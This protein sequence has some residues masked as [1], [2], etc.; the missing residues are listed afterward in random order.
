MRRTITILA[1]L[2]LVFAGSCQRI[3]EGLVQ[4]GPDVIEGEVLTVEASFGDFPDTKTAIQSD[5]KSIFWTPGDAINLFFG[6]ISSAKFTTS[7]SMTE[8]SATASFTGTLGAATGSSG[9]GFVAP[10]FWGV[11][12]YDADNTCDGTSVA[13]WIKSEQ[14]AGPGT[15]GNGMSPSV[16]NAPGLGLSFKNVGSWFK[17][18][19]SQEGIT[20]ATF[21]GNNGEILAGRVTVTMDSDGNPL[22]TRILAGS[23]RITVTPEGGGS[24]VPNQ[25]YYITLIP[26]TISGAT[27]Y[28]LTLYK[29]AQVGKLVVADP[30]KTYTFARSNSRSKTNADAGITWEDRY[31]EMAAGFNWAKVNIG[32]ASPEEYG[33]YFAWGETSPRDFYISDNY[34]YLIPFNDAATANRGD[35]WRTPT[36]AEWEALLD[37]NNYTWE[38]TTENGVNGYRVTSKVAGYAGNSI[39]LPTAGYSTN[40][41]VWNTGTTGH[42][43]SSSLNATDARIANKVYIASRDH[44]II[45]RE[46]F[47]GYS[48]RAVY[49][50]SYVPPVSPEV[51]V[52][53][54]SFDMNQYVVTDRDP[55]TLTATISPANATIQDLTWVSSDPSVALISPTGVV[56]GLKVGTTTITVRTVDG[57]YETSCNVTVIPNVSYLDMGNGTKWAGWNVGASSP[58][59]WGNFYAWA[60]TQ[61]KTSYTWSTYNYGSSSSNVTIYTATD[62][63]TVL[64]AGDDAATANL[65]VNWR[66]PTEGEWTWLLENCTWTYAEMNGNKGYIVKSNVS[67]YSNSIIFLPGAGIHLN[68]H[69]N[70]DR[71]FYWSSN[72]S[73]DTYS[74]AKYAVIYEG[75]GRSIKEQYRCYGASVRPIYEP[76]QFLNGHEYVEMGD[77]L[78]WATCNIGAASPEAYG[79]YF[80]WGETAPK[81]S[82]SDES[83]D[84][85]RTFSDAAAANWGGTWRMPTE[86]EWE[87]LLD[88]ANFD[89]EWDDV[90]KGCK[91]TSKVPGYVGNS[92]FLPAAGWRWDTRLN[93]AGSVGE[94]WTPALYEYSS[95]DARVMYFNSEGAKLSAS[96]RSLGLSVRPVS[97]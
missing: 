73:T 51:P 90:R 85:D 10:T 4:E 6:N 61:T 69:G 27:G 21:E 54:V 28:T 46:R 89:W 18:S 40:G 60:E 59:E 37:E 45:E 68:S 88:T 32:A 67:G 17:F 70:T 5:G 82:Y 75:G 20:S 86:A 92:I 76:K 35:G 39:F 25:Y 94:Y 13:L 48:I 41:N 62:G 74:K 31:V 47:F 65:G 97:E 16:A 78:K 22:I 57:G 93:D 53:G 95:Y 29:G 91:V 50:P 33:E 72:V 44:S 58:E 55:S 23:T 49:D 12:P 64:E 81:S 3:E 26:Q 83:C 63:K 84:Y 79:D 1:A 15:F 87:A 38:W 36:S 7:S 66:T 11:Y 52:T 14:T 24:F 71:C 77:G 42:Y 19:V 34:D 43:W 8:P 96:D 2:G 30:T 9:D 80:A 56:T